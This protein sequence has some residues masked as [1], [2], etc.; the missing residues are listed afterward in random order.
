M[1]SS[2]SWGVLKLKPMVKFSPEKIRKLTFFLTVAILVL[3]V[4][5]HAAPPEL[6]DLFTGGW[7]GDSQSGLL[8]CNAEICTNL[9]QLLELLNNLLYFGLTIL[10]YVIVPV[11]IL[12]GGFLIM[13]AA[14]SERLSQGKSIIKGTLIG[15]LIAFG[16]FAIVATFLWMIGNNSVESGQPRV[17]WPQIACS[18]GGSPYAP[19]PESGTGT[20]DEEEG[21]GTGQ[22]ASNHASNLQQLQAAGIRVTT[23]GGDQYVRENCDGVSGP[24]TTLR[25]LPQIAVDGLINI[26]N[27]CESFYQIRDPLLVGACNVIVTGGTEP[28]HMTHGPGKAIV[29]ID[30]VPAIDRFIIREIL[31]IPEPTEITPNK[32]YDAPGGARYMYETNPLHW[33]ICFAEP[34]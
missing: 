23:T 12:I 17:S 28:G 16:A 18:P 19:L 26:K 20:G 1:R 21:D 9:C 13:T 32:F 2:N 33:H 25:G 3:P 10:L 15:V 8:A 4:A 30:N 29:D 31:G 5:T 24:C 11:R 7:W 27:G 14:A 22:P 6:T 34:C